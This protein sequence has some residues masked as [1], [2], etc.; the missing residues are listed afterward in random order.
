MLR[1]LLSLLLLVFAL[2]F[3]AFATTL[4]RPPPTRPPM[5]WWC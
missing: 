3:V 1:R 5:P 4:P 2:G